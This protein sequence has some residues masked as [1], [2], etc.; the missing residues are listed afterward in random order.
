MK[1]YKGYIAFD[2]DC[3][4]ASYKRPFKIDKLG[5]PQKE[6]IDV[7]HH[8]YNEGYYILI[9]TGRIA[10]KKMQKW[11]KKNNVPF[12]GFNQNPS[13]MLGTSEKKPYYNIIIDDKSVNY[14]W[15]YNKKS[16]K[17]IINEINEKISWLND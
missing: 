3:V 15:K 8:F 2:F 13:P 12:H 14:H 6:I 5:K 10:T 1:N 17:N 9:F 4:I 16:T 11:L 7:M